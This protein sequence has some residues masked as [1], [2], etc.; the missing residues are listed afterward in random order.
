MRGVPLHSYGRL[1]PVEYDMIRTL[2]QI[3]DIENGRGGNAQVYR[4]DILAL[5]AVARAAKGIPTADDM[6]RDLNS[7]PWQQSSIDALCAALAKLDAALE[8]L[9]EKATQ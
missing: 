2:E 8:P 3:E 5:V 1:L 9:L 7:G 4:S 6:R